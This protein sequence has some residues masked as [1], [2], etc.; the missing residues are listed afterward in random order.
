[1][2]LRYGRPLPRRVRSPPQ[3]RFGRCGGRPQPKVGMRVLQRWLWRWEHGC[4]FARSPCRCAQC[5]DIGVRGRPWL[6]PPVPPASA[7]AVRATRAPRCPTGG[8]TGRHLGPAGELPLR[9]DSRSVGVDAEPSLRLPSCQ[10][11]PFPTIVQYTEPCSSYRHDTSS[12]TRGGHLTPRLA[13]VGAS[14]GDLGRPLRL[15]GVLGC[16]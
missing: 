3:A 6:P 2:T 8:G 14:R 9:L 13:S 10:L 1:M 12:S 16:P 7:V 11:E 4:S 5:G 15:D